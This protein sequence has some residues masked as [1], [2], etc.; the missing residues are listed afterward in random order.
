MDINWG[1]VIVSTL[2]ATVVSTIT[3]NVL[4]YK[5]VKKLESF[6]ENLLDKHISE[7]NEVINKN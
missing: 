5:R 4:M 2:V 7:L 1:T 3:V 6:A